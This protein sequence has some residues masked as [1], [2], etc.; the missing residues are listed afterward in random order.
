MA[1]RNLNLLS[2]E[3]CCIFLFKPIDI[4]ADEVG[5]LF[6][7]SKVTVEKLDVEAAIKFVKA[8]A[9]VE[10]IEE[11][12]L[13]KLMPVRKYTRGKAPG[14]TTK[15]IWNRLNQKA[16][17]LARGEKIPVSK[18]T[19][20][21][22]NINEEDKAK[23]V[24]KVIEIAIREIMGNH[25]YSF[26]GQTYLQTEGGAIGLRLTGLVARV[27]MDHWAV[28]MRRK[29]TINK[30]ETIMMSKYVDD[31][32]TILVHIGEGA[33]WNN[34]LG[35]IMW[36]SKDIEEDINNKKSNDKITMDVWREMASSIY[37][38]LKFT[39]DIAEDHEHGAVT[40]LDVKV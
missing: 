18:W 5:R 38:F 39:M 9:T 35:K 8:G 37:E 28:L 12:E 40:V 30:I 31:V 32:F 15:E 6:V 10:E 34:Q 27:V 7:K 14:I 23:L 1:S 4:C 3:G 24:G 22:T 17:M 20:I 29:M 13:T 26:D 36:E 25:M 16:E 33:R 21:V 19:A 11:A 2:V